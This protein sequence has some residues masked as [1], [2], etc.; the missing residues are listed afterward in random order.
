MNTTIIDKARKLGKRFLPFYL[1]TLLSLF[2]SCEDDQPAF[3]QREV[4]PPPAATTAFASGADISSV[5]EFTAKGVKF[6]NKAGVETECTQIMKELGMNAIRLRVWVN[7]KADAYCD[8]A[9]VLAKAL[10]VKAQG[11]RLMIDFHYSDT[12]ADPG[13]QA[14]PKAWADYDIS[15]LREAIRQHTVDVLQ[16]L[17]DNGIDVE[18]VQVGNETT[19]GMM[20]PLG[21]AS[22]NMENYALLTTEGYDAVKSVYPQA[23][24]IVHIDKATEIGRFT[25]IFNRLKLFEAKW[26]IIGMSFYPE[27]WK[28]ETDAV[29]DN[30]ISLSERFGTPCMIVE[31][32]MLRNDPAEG[33]KAMAYLF[34]QMMNHTKGYC[35]G[36]LYWEPET[37]RESGYDKGAFSDGGRPTETLAPFDMSQY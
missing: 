2:V 8:K 33:K 21:K 36:I 10:K 7:P 32:G 34:D 1:L 35:R 3:K 18:W 12:W 37:Y 9:D 17:K 20:W 14:V 31:T 4:V 5:T 29:V 25:G 16:T 22:D 19:D 13:Q 28:S 23:Q 11:M 24:V 30:I 27:V 15:Q 6:Y 26:D